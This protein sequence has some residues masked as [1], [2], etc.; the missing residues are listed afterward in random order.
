I[1][2]VDMALWDIKGKLAGM[3][4]YQ[5]LGGAA[6]EGCMVYGHANGAT[7]EETI[8]EAVRHVEEGYKAVRLQAG[9]PGLKSTYGVAK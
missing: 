5:L 6:R 3:R 7:I 9:V 4:V 8:A 2:A 1:A